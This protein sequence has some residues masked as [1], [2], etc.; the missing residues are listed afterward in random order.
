MDVMDSGFLSVP[1]FVVTGLRTH[2][3]TKKNLSI[4]SF[5][6]SSVGLMYARIQ[7]RNS[8]NFYIKD[9]I[10]HSFSSAK[11]LNALSNVII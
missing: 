10:F 9:K 11:Y 7:I 1:S 2:G 8:E 6:N 3:F 4:D 5:I